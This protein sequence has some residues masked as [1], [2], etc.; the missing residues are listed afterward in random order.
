MLLFPFRDEAGKDRF[1]QRFFHDRETVKRDRDVAALTWRRRQTTNGEQR[2][3]E[4]SGRN[5]R[6]AL[7]SSPRHEAV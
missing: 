5:K 6:N 1:L 3:N 7:G 2:R 4:Q